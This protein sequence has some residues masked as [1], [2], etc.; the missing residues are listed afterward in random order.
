MKEELA[1]RPVQRERE[2]ALYEQQTQ[3]NKLDIFKRQMEGIKQRI[4]KVTKENYGGL[5]GL[6]AQDMGIHPENDL[7]WPS[8][9]EFKT[10]SPEKIDE[11]KQRNLMDASQWLKVDSPAAAEALEREQ[12]EKRKEREYEE[13]QAKVK[14]EREKE[15]KMIE[16]GGKTEAEKRERIQELEDQVTEIR[17]SPLRAPDQEKLIEDIKDKIKKLKEGEGKPDLTISEMNRWAGRAGKKVVVPEPSHKPVA[18]KEKPIKKPKRKTKPKDVKETK[19][20]PGKKYPRFK[21]VTLKGEEGSILGYGIQ[22][23][24]HPGG[25]WRSA[26]QKEKEDFVKRELEE[27]KKMSKERRGGRPVPDINFLERLVK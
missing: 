18:V 11:W 3:L 13:E 19:S 5:A 20:L 17:A 23:Q 10:W 24:D 25:K 7:G 26:T 14:H 9:E 4:P 22:V 6:I 8:E 1:N 21:R 27:T 12:D 2:G 16:F 15:L